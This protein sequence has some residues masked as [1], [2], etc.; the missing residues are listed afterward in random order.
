METLSF[1]PRNGRFPIVVLAGGPA[2][3]GADFRR[4][5]ERY[6]IR[7]V[8]HRE[9]KRPRKISEPL[10]PSVDLVLI[11]TD[12]I[13]HT[14]YDAIRKVSR[15]TNVPFLNIHRKWSVSSQRLERSGLL[16]S[17]RSNSDI[18]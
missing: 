18:C 1:T 13:S 12:M 7:I 15:D 11:L 16:R 17:W 4:R 10:P 9:W 6:G 5:F 3:V 14:D 8:E 2:D